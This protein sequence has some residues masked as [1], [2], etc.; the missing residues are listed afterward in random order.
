MP[1]GNIGNIKQISHLKSAFEAKNI[2]A[3]AV[4]KNDFMNSI[5][6]GLDSVQKLQDEAN[7]KVKQVVTDSNKD[8]SEALVSMLK[9]EISMQL[10]LQVRNK[11]IDAYQEISK[12]P[13]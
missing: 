11:L 4:S 7:D 2:G 8:P 10:T 12:M 3:S 1:I 5:K 13:I 9:A 6:E